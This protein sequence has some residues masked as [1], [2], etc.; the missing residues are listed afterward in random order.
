V[1]VEGC[2]EVEIE[3]W[4]GFKAVFSGKIDVFEIVF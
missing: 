1:D 2:Q 3:S 4:L